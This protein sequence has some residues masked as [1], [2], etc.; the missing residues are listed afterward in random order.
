MGD[1]EDMVVEYWGWRGYGCRIWGMGRTWMYN[2]G[3]GGK[4]I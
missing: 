4:E 3:D 1:G 2:L